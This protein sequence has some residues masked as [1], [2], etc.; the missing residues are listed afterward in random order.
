MYFSAEHNARLAAKLFNHVRQGT[1][2]LADDLM[3]IDLSV[4][5]DPAVAAQERERIFERLPIMAAHSSQIGNPD[6]FITVQLNRT[7]VI[8]TR[9]KDGGVKALVNA[10]R[11]RG[12]TVVSQ[13]AGKRALFTCPYHGW[14]YSNDGTLRAISFAD[15]F[16]AFPCPERNLIR[17]P[18]EERHGFVWVVENPAGAIDVATHLGPGMDSVLA[19][20]QFDKYFGYKQEVFQFAQNW[21]IMVDGLIDGYHVQFLHGKTISPHFYPN[22]NF[23][24]IHGDH[25]VFGTPRRAIEKILEEIPGQSPLDRYVAFGN[26]ISPNSVMVLHPHHIEY[27][28]MYQNPKDVNQCRAHLRYLTPQQTYDEEGQRIIQKNWDIATAAIIN[29]DVPAGNGIQRSASMPFLS[30]ICLGRNEVSN[31]LFHRAYRRYMSG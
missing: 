15:T 20:Y 27:W 12:S 31:Q 11:H 17:L 9:Q 6:S 19:A 18:V 5:S 2:D 30:K 16:G 8:L 3:E 10:C 22:M 21:K 14:T 24:D 25:A 1:T 13:P 7:N 26:L 28:T 29:E 23:I 4:Y